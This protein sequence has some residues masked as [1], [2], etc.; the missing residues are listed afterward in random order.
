MNEDPAKKYSFFLNPNPQ[1]KPID[2]DLVSLDPVRLG[3][4]EVPV[5]QSACAIAIGDHAGYYKQGECAI[6]IGHEAGRTVQS[7]HALAVGVGAGEAQQGTF[8]V[9]LGYQAGNVEQSSM[10][11]AL[12]YQAGELQQGG[13]ALAIG[14]QAGQLQ[15]GDVGLAVGVQAGAFVQQPYAV[16]VGYQAGYSGQATQ[17]VAIGSQAGR[18]LQGA[19]AVALGFQAGY[20]NQGTFAIALG[21]YAGHTAQPANS[22]VLNASGAPL[23]GVTSGAWYVHPV[24][25]ATTASTLYYNPTSKEVSY[26][27][28]PSGGGGSA[29]PNITYAMDFSTSLMSTTVP[30]GGS[31][32]TTLNP[33]TSIPAVPTQ[34]SFTVPATFNFTIGSGG[35]FPDLQ[36]ALASASVTNGMNLRILAGT[37]AIPDTTGIVISKQVGI[38]G[39]SASSVVLQTTATASAPVYALS[40]RAPNVTLYGIKIQHRKSSN[41][42]VEAAVHVADTSVSPSTGLANVRIVACQIEYM[43][44]GVVMSGDS[45]QIR[46]CMAIA[47]ESFSNSTRRAIGVYRTTGNSFI[48]NNW[49]ANNNAAG[50]LRFIALTASA[51]INVNEIFSGNLVIQGNV[52]LANSPLAQFYNQDS[53]ASAGSSTFSLYVDQNHVSETSAFVVVYIGAANAG[54]MLNNVVITNNTCSNQHGKG[55]FTVDAGSALSF[56]SIGALPVFFSKNVVGSIA[57]LGAFA[58]APGATGNNVG[59][60]ATNVTN[61]SVTQT[62]GPG[63]AV[64]STV[65]GMGFLPGGTYTPT[66]YAAAA[67]PATLSYKIGYTAANG[68]GDA[69]SYV[70]WATGTLTVT[71][72]TPT[73]YT[74]PTFTTGYVQFLTQAVRLRVE[75]VNTDSTTLTVYSRDPTSGRLVVPM[76]NTPVTYLSG[77]QSIPDTIA[78]SGF[79]DLVVAYPRAFATAPAVTC[80]TTGTTN[81]DYVLTSIVSTTPIGF[82][83]RLRNLTSASASALSI[84]WIACG[85]VAV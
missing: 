82:T 43:E 47:Y 72:S 17:T 84:H 31:V 24:A 12:G 80:T 52:Q 35:D 62:V 57:F 14:T 27:P 45:F 51:P 3:T 50:T 23:N 74:L 77:I 75:L 30:S 22:I 28:A 56:R 36:T 85:S 70:V 34:P 41:T 6:A 15:Q 64:V 18:S 71:S 78:G 83:A 46:D 81:A 8:A 10:A 63:T 58:L 1:K 49:I 60:N 25:S 61:A 38:Y 54:N 5:F 76:Y 66:I 2:F 39:V 42:T 44:F 29:A 53:F 33:S 32:S 48:T 9:A 73:A 26:G 19:N 69:G 4:I 55:L 13:H 11:V 40:I 59:Y 7:A 67:S 65:L 20:A 79:V 21:A 68:F 16:A 37:Y